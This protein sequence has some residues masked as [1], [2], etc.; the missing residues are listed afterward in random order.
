MLCLFLVKSDEKKCEEAGG[1]HA[2][3]ET[4][5]K[6]GRERHSISGRYFALSTLQ[7]LLPDMYISFS[8]SFFLVDISTAC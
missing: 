6:L 4:E 5:E 7:T 3:R 8:F 2:W 1:L